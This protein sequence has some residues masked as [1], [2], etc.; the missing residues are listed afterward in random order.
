VNREGGKAMAK[1]Y[2]DGNLKE[3]CC[4]AASDI[5]VLSRKVSRAPID[6]ENTNNVAEYRAVL[7]GLYKH[8]EATEVCSDSRLVVKQLNGKYAVKSQG[9]LPYW[10]R[11]KT[12]VEKLGHD[13]EFIWV[14][15]GENPAGRILK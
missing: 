4:V 5:G 9:L 11:V 13:V 14:P 3:V 2:V 6:G 10:L 1:I 12:R 7:F 8:P 15:R